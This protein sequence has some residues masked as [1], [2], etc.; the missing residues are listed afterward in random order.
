MTPSD[1]ND[2]LAGASSTLVNDLLSSTLSEDDIMDN[3]C[4]AALMSFDQI[5]PTYR[6]KFIASLLMRFDEL[7][8]VRP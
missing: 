7:G 1:I 8:E 6:A 5:K 3:I 4:D 2:R